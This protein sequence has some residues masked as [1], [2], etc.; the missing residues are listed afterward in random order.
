MYKNTASSLC[1]AD[2]KQGHHRIGDQ[3]ARRA[4]ASRAV[5]DVLNLR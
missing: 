3:A 5:F 1:C 4:I 2:Y